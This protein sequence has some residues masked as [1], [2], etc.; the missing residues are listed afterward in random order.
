MSNITDQATIDFVKL[1]IFISTFMFWIYTC[2]IRTMAAGHCHSLTIY[3]LL[4]T[5]NYLWFLACTTYSV[6]IGM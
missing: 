6:L 2:F 1:T 5:N 4:T 3:L